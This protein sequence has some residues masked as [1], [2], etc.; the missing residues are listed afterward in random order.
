[1][2]EFT[3]SHLP[4]QLRIKK[5]LSIIKKIL[6]NLSLK[7]YMSIA[8]CLVLKVT[9]LW[10]F[11][12]KQMPYVLKLNLKKI[13]LNLETAL[14]GRADSLLSLSKTKIL[15]LKLIFLSRKY[16][17]LPWFLLTISSSL[18]NLQLSGYCLSQR[19]SER[20]TQFKRFTSIKYMILI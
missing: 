17:T 14:S 5:A 13:C 19:Q 1:M 15:L 7:I 12:S 4:S 3:P 16:L 8:L 6:T 2:I 11:N 18:M 10:L 20:L 9:T